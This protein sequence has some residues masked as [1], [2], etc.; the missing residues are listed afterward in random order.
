MSVKN[1]RTADAVPADLRDDDGAVLRY[2]DQSEPRALDD[3]VAAL[4]R[5]LFED[6]RR[7]S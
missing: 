2:A 3:L 7:V 4:E 6:P 5:L 1:T